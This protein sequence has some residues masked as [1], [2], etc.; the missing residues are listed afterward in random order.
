M[1]SCAHTRRVFGN[2]QHWRWH[3]TRL[4]RFFSRNHDHDMNFLSGLS[5]T[6]TDK[7]IQTCHCSEQTCNLSSKRAPES[8][9]WWRAVSCSA[10]VQ[11]ASADKKTMWVCNCDSLTSIS[12]SCF[13]WSYLYGIL[14]LNNCGRISSS[15]PTTIFLRNWY[16]RLLLWKE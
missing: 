11:R 8:L 7:K 13:Q 16:K 12:A 3:Q 9:P 6:T 1:C 14:F 10:G 4:L 2:T 15:L 5:V